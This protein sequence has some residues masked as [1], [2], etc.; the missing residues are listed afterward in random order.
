M[1]NDDSYYNWADYIR[2]LMA[3]HNSWAAEAQRM[4]DQLRSSGM[5]SAMAEAQRVQDQ[6]RSSGMLSAIAEAQRVQDQLR[7]SGML[8]AMAEAQRVQD[9]LRSSGMLSAMA[10]AQKMKTYIATSVINRLSEMANNLRSV[11]YVINPDGTITGQNTIFRQNEVQ[12]IIESYLEKT[13]VVEKNSI[14]ITIDNMLSNIAKHHPIITKIIVHILLALF[15]NVVSARYFSPPAQIDYSLLAKHLKKEV[16]QVEIGPEF[17]RHYRFVSAPSLTVWSKNYTR[18]KYV[19][20]LY[21]GYLVRIVQKNKNWSLIEYRAN[22][23]TAVIQG[24]VF[25]R[26]L[27]RF[28]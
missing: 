21:F 9:Q 6:L 1:M 26:Y 24:W 14:E 20:K 13:S 16:H 4:Q 28:D 7:S 12:E 3:Q 8:S 27:K 11:D 18:S 23:G 15:I 2:K 5:L 19:G 17:Y 25:T 22:D 10:D